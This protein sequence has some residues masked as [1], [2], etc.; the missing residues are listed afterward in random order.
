[1][2]SGKSFTSV[3]FGFFIANFLTLYT[4]VHFYTMKKIR[5]TTLSLFYSALLFVPHPMQAASTGW[6]P[7][8][9]TAFCFCITATHGNWVNHYEGNF[10]MPAH[11]KGYDVV[12]LDDGRVFMGGH[13]KNSTLLVMMDKE[14][15]ILWGKY[16]SGM[17]W[18][19]MASS[20]HGNF[21]VVGHHSN[22][23]NSNHTTFFVTRFDLQGPNPI[24]I[25]W[26][27]QVDMP[28]HTSLYDIKVT[29]EGGLSA[30]GSLPS[31]S[32]HTKSFLFTYDSLGNHWLGGTLNT[33]QGWDE[34]FSVVDEGDDTLSIVGAAIRAITTNKSVLALAFH[35][36]SW[37]DSILTFNDSRLFYI[38]NST[39]MLPSLTYGMKGIKHL[40]TDDYGYLVT[41]NIVSTLG[42][43]SNTYL[44]ITKF[45]AEGSPL[46]FRRAA[47]PSLAYG[48]SRTKAAHYLVAGAM[49]TDGHKALRW[50]TIDPLLGTLIT[51]RGLIV[52]GDNL[53]L[54]PSFQVRSDGATF[55]AMASA[56]DMLDGIIV[57]K[58]LG[59]SFTQC[60]QERSFPFTMIDLIIGEKFTAGNLTISMLPALEER[61][62]ISLVSLPFSFEKNNLCLYNP[63]LNQNGD[64][65]LNYYAGHAPIMSLIFLGIL[66]VIP[67]SIYLFFR[68]KRFCQC[69]VRRPRNFF[70]I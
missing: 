19:G 41:G 13:Y 12:P 34:A 39:T 68:G 33:P 7:T 4:T 42:N 67:I 23:L 16:W 3:D 32:T 24:D 25:H 27:R 50:F 63:T 2:Q 17:S 1:M 45:D 38:G 15:K 6:F 55:L 14:G 26:V 43:E 22:S 51:S 66:V 70:V 61:S 56:S 69:C 54:P 48:L 9:V 60:A 35:K 44:F 52:G 57:G 21:F 65:R 11:G 31:N 40:R 28:L 29:Q 36:V 18:D 53:T 64:N 8:L 30:V 37:V 5:F 59:E 62:D 20:D 47:Y 46:W 58:W 49:V 10:S